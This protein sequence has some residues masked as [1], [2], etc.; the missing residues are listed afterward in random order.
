MM[1]MMSGSNWTCPRMMQQFI[2][3]STRTTT[4]T[5]TTTRGLMRMTRAAYLDRIRRAFLLRVHPDRFRNQSQQ[6]RQMQAQLVQALSNRLNQ[7]D[8][9]QWTTTTTRPETTTRNVTDSSSS[10]S[11]LSL[12][13]YVMEQRDGSLFQGQLQLT[14]NRSVQ[15]ILVDMTRALRQCGAGATLPSTHTL[16]VPDSDLLLLLS[17]SSSSPPKPN[18]HHHRSITK[19]PTFATTN[20]TTYPHHTKQQEQQQQK[21]PEQQQEQHDATTQKNHDQNQTHQ[22]FFFRSF[23][24][25]FVNQGN[26]DQYNRVSNQGRDLLYFVQQLSMLQ[27]GRCYEVEERKLA[28][29]HAQA[30][31]LAVRRMYQFQAVDAVTYLGWSSTSVTQLLKRL[32]DL[33]TE[34]GSRQFQVSSFYPLRLVSSPSSSI[35]TTSTSQPPSSSSPLKDGT[36]KN[37]NENKDAPGENGDS[38]TR[39]FTTLSSSSENEYHHHHTT[40]ADDCTT[41]SLSTTLDVYGGILY[42]HPASTTL[43]WLD[44]LRHVTKTQISHVVQY[45][46]QLEQYK[47]EL[48]TQLNWT[49]IKGFTCSSRD[50]YQVVK[51]LITLSHHQRRQKMTR[52]ESS[53]AEQLLDNDDDGEEKEDIVNDNTTQFLW[54]PQDPLHIKIEAHTACHPSHLPSISRDGMV[55]LS[56]AMFDD[57]DDKKEEERRLQQQWEQPIQ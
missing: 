37:Q 52:K 19:E 21:E 35:A 28:R 16:T 41:D 13:S 5:T 50:Y 45:R 34:H 54:L 48:T 44:I 2:Q 49:V 38:T 55:V 14:A 36:T 17:S 22:S 30:A 3:S 42:L 51:L 20:S 4:I 1:M 23:D 40:A 26:A 57:H 10:S 33:H 39:A 11:S 6:I 43:Q 47:H 46:S 24:R 8:V 32:L 12:Y 7:C 56:L 18:H 25:Q 53:S 15:E 31:A 29:M 9:Q 27:R